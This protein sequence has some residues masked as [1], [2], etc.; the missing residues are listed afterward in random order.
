MKKPVQEMLDGT[1]HTA[2]SSAVDGDGVK[3]EGP[4]ESVDTALGQ[5]LEVESSP[6]LEKKVLLKID[7]V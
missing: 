5:I 6:E 3:L 1:P 4:I 7:L 2:A